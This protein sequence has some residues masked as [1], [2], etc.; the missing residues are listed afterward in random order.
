MAPNC[1]IPEATVGSRSTATRVT[2]GAISL[3]RGAGVD[4][5]IAALAPAQLLQRLCERREAGASFRIVRVP[6]H[7]HADAPHALPCCACTASGH[8]ADAVPSSAMNSRRFIIR[9]HGPREGATGEEP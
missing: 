1:P 7:V 4:A 8:A 6:I 9:S 3:S 5:Q 2:A